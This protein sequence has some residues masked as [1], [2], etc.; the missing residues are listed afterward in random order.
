VVVGVR[1]EVVDV[2]VNGDVVRSIGS[3][4]E[5][6]GGVI[7]LSCS[8]SAFSAFARFAFLSFLVGF[9][10]NVASSC[11]ATPESMLALRFS[12]FLECEIGKRIMGNVREDEV[13]NRL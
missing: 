12:L 13:V 7:S 10:S 11:S 1:D 2:I 8:S 3:L 4:S 6:I 5:T 9:L